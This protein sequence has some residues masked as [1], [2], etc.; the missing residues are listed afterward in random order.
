MTAVIFLQESQYLI[1]YVLIALGLWIL[2]M[3]FRI[4]ETWYANKTNKV[5]YRDIFVFRTLS[6]KRKPHLHNN[7]FYKKLNKRQQRRLEHRI[8]V[9]LGET[10][11]I[12]RENLVITDQMK[13]DIAATAMMITLGRKN[14]SYELVDNIL[15][16]PDVFYSNANDA[17]HKGEFNPMQKTI[18]FSWKDFKHGHS[19]LDDNLNVGIHEFAHALQIGAKKAHDIDSIRLERVFQKILHHLTNQ[20]VKNRLDQVKYF[21]A[22]AFTNQYEFLAVLL[23][24]FFESPGDFKNYFPELYKYTRA[25]LNFNFAGY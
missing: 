19:I 4:C 21:R 8:C 25:M 18:V 16:Y 1:P 2:F 23:E 17:Y 24:Y 12:G 5:I 14:Y 13:I 9:F 15:L 22:Y 10:R 20:D 3:L 6:R 7:V 11:F